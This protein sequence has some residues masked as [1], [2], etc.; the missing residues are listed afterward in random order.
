MIAR[1]NFFHGLLGTFLAMAFAPLAVWAEPKNR[2]TASTTPAPV[3]TET[4]TTKVAVAHLRLWMA[5]DAPDRPVQIRL[6]PY[7][8]SASESISPLKVEADNYH[9]SGYVE[10][11]VGPMTAE[12]S[13]PERATVMVPLH[14]ADGGQSTLLVRAQGTNLTAEWID[15]TPGSSDG[16]EF[17]VYNLLPASGDIQVEVGTILTVHLSSMRSSA[18]LSGIKRANYPVLTHGVDGNGKDFHSNNEVD[19]RQYR[20]A[21]LLIYPDAYGRIRPR[22]N[23]V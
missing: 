12:V 15:D 1:K 11:P 7:G 10:V 14:L 17:C 3:A 13:A 21:A 8:K 19:F 9:F 6:S 2:R 20:K 4:P 16:G 18:R 23:G 5:T 22:I